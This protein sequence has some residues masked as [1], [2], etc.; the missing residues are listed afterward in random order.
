MEGGKKCRISAQYFQTVP[1]IGK[2]KTGR[3]CANTTFHSTVLGL[4]MTFKAK[5]N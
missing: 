5:M 4:F 3:S 1:A 2:K